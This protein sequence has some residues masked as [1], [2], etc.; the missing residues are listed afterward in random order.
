M[1]VSASYKTDIPAFYGEWFANRLRAGYCKMV[2]PFNRHQVFTVSL[3]REDVDGFIFWTKNLGPFIDTLREVHTSG[4]PFIVQYSINAY[5]R[6]LESRVVDAGRSIGHMKMLAKEYG[7]H[8]GVWRYDTIV[9]SSLTDRD[10]HL[11]NFKN[12]ANELEGST[13]EV[14]ISFA[15]LYKKTRRNLDVASD[16]QGFAWYDPS[17]EEKRELALELAG[18]AHEHK[19]QL[20]VCSQ[21]DLVVNGTQEARCID[22]RRL[23]TVAGRFID[24]KLKGARKECG[25]FYAKDIGDYDTCPHGCTYCYAVQTRELALRRYREHDPRSEFLHAR[26]ADAGSLPENKPPSLP[27]NKAPQS[28]T[29][30]EASPCQMSLFLSTNK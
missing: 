6:A 2:N 10:F 19:M 4:Y 17:P 18:I 9:H 8:L 11:K 30:K 29:N 27:E 28:H 16:E 22:A 15:Q 1:I 24:S 3:R 26:S 14:V 23:S 12:L 21:P 20:T 13:D 7:P 5:P 25:C